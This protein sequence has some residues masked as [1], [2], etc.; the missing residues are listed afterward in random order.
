METKWTDNLV[1]RPPRFRADHDFIRIEGEGIYRECRESLEALADQVG[2]MKNRAARTRFALGEIAFDVLTEDVGFQVDGVA[3]GTIC[4]VSVLVG[5]GDH[6]NFGD[7]AM[8]AGDG[9]ANAV[10]GEGTLRNHVGGEAGGD[11]DA[12][13][14]GVAMLLEMGDVADGVDVAEDEVAAEF[15]AGG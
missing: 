11:V 8:P 2:Y 7:A 10:D 5:V 12:Q 1:S 4:N 13:E 14:P 9:E 3:G 6:G 15:L